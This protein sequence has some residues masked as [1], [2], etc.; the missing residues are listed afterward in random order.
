MNKIT[1]ERNELMSILTDTVPVIQ[2]KPVVL[3][4]QYGCIAVKGGRIRVKTSNTNVSVKRYGHVI[5]S[6]GDCE[7]VTDVKKIMSY[8]GKIP[9]GVI[10]MKVTEE[11]VEIIHAH[12]HTRMPVFSSADFPDMSAANSDFKNIAI[13]STLLKDCVEEAI[14]FV[15]KDVIRPQLCAI[16]AYVKDGKF[17]YCATDTHMLVHDSMQISE[18]PQDMDFDFFILPEIAKLLARKCSVFPTIKISRSDK[19]VRYQTED[20]VM[21]TVMPNGNFPNFER[22]IPRTS[23]VSCEVDTKAVS[24][25]LSRILVSC[26]NAQVVKM[27]LNI[28]DL[29]LSVEDLDEGT[30]GMENIELCDAPEGTITIG[31]N[32]TYLAI[33]LAHCGK[34]ANIRMSDSSRPALFHQE[35]KPSHIIMCMPMSL[36]NG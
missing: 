29:A 27:S 14:D 11:S 8:L 19:K 16:Y 22:V 5:E 2:N 7:F 15:A 32:P 31:F 24:N 1:I 9:P 4:Q 34:T 21:E 28:T 3:I 17:G 33:C 6:D 26:N 13:P 35:D 20:M 23:N 10:T 30:M 18:I 12:G 25:A 36:I